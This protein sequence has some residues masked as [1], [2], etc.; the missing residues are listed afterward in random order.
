MLSKW[1]NGRHGRFRIYSFIGEG[2]IPS[3]DI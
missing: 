3:F 1:W 2:S